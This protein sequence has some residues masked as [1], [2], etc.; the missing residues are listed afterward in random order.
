MSARKW[1]YAFLLVAIILTATG[2]SRTD[3]RQD[4]GKVELKVIIAGSL[5]VPFQAIEKEFERDNPDI[6]VLLE[7]HGSVQ[8][9]RCVTELGDIADLTAV[10]DTQLIPAMMYST[11]IPGSDTP[12]A[13]WLVKFSANRLGIAYKDESAY[14][15]EINADN[16]YEIISRPDVSIGLA[17]PR[18]DA[19][20]YRTLMT[21]QLAEDY[22]SDNTIFERTIGDAFNPPLVVSEQGGDFNIIV[23]E[24]VKSNQSRVKLRS[25]SI[26]LMALLESGDLDYSF[27]YESVAKQR[28]LKFLSLPEAIDLSSPDYNKQYRQVEVNLDFKRFA[29]VIPSFKGTQIVYGLTIP[30]NAQHPGEAERLI[31]YVLSPD[32]RRI[33]EQ[34]HQPLL[35]TPVCDNVQALPESLQPLF[36]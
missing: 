13:D 14:S 10:A 9:I 3:T 36:R 29:S 6:D 33:F 19:M 25:Y 31:E 18:I 23:P 27:E 1:V 26:Q 4:N 17:D 34:C 16:W 15:S 24:I 22:Y 30:E 8:A 35:A 32:G 2:C 21:M 7:G 28:G 5:M 20:G 12:Y 11:R